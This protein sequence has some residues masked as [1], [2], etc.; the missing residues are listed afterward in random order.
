MSYAIRLGSRGMPRPSCSGNCFVPVQIKLNQMY[1]ENGSRLAENAQALAIALTG[2]RRIPVK[3]G[4]ACKGGGAC[5]TCS[6]GAAEVP[7]GPERLFHCPIT[8]S[9][10]TLRHACQ[11]GSPDHPSLLCGSKSIT[12]CAAHARCSAPCPALKLGISI[13]AT[14]FAVPNRA[15]HASLRL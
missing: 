13:W 7:T 12:W 2:A 9:Q 1:A 5:P 3:A 6:L 10:H 11:V 15:V 4:T 8:R 14:S